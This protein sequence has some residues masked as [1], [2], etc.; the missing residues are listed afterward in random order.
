MFSLTSI[1]LS[2]L[3]AL[4]SYCKFYS[5]ANM[6][7]LN[8][9]KVANALFDPSY[10][11][12]AIFVGG[13]SGIGQGLAEAFARHTKG[14]AHIVIIGRNRAAADSIIAQFPKPADSAKYTHEF[15]QCDVTRMKNI[16]SV[17][18]ELLT[19][20]PKINFLFMSPGLMTMKGRDETEEGI[21]TKLA[22]HYYARWKFID[23]LLPA[24]VKAKDAGEDAKVLSVLAAGVG[25]EINLDDLGLKKTFSVANAALAAPTYNDL[26]LQDFAAKYP[27]LTFVHSYPGVVRTSIMS[28]SDSVWLK[29]AS[30]VVMQ[31]MR[32]F[33]ASLQDSGEYMLH[34]LLSNKKGFF[35]VGSRGED[36]GMKRYFGSE[37]ARKKLWDHTVAATEVKGAS[38]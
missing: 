10:S 5:A 2:L 13:T 9:A 34:G 21:D 14:N 24:L 27:A 12:V 8:A 33:S 23:N 31:L 11:P 16:E 25:G 3:V 20:I 1:L 28:S 18:T 32:P 22:V 36:L 29:A 38:S 4:L 37:E 7:T 19:R 30:P 17:T 35:R 6:P 26:M 15:V